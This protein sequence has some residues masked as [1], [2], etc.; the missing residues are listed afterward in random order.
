MNNPTFPGAE[1]ESYTK[2]KVRMPMHTDVARVIVVPA[3][4]ILLNVAADPG[5][6]MDKV[7]W[8]MEQ[9]AEY[10][11]DRAFCLLGL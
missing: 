10:L 5:C 2:R 7:C 3:Q 4:R 9:Y 6:N 1:L 8:S 11:G